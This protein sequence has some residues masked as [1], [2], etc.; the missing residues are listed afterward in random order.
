MTESKFKFYADVPRD[1]PESGTGI[2]YADRPHNSLP[3]NVWVGGY[4]VRFCDTYFNALLALREETDG[5]TD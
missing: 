4:I 5:G 1:K 3:F 2:Q